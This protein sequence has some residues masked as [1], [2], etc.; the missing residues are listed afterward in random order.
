VGNYRSLTARASAGVHT[1][2]NA[3]IEH[4][5]VGVMIPIP[6]YPLYTA[7]LALYNAKAVPYY[8]RETEDWGMSVVFTAN[9]RLRI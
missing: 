6:Q 7:S 4:D 9:V 1:I 8:L 2:L 5:K 3:I